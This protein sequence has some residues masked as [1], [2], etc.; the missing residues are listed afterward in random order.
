MLLDLTSADGTVRH[1][2]FASGSA[3]NNSSEA[4]ERLMNKEEIV[5][6]TPPRYQLGRPL[7]APQRRARGRAPGPRTGQKP[8]RN[9]Y[10]RELS[11]DNARPVSR[12]ERRRSVSSD[13][14][15]SSVAANNK[16]RSPSRSDSDASSRSVSRNGK[17]P[18]TDHKL[19]NTD[20]QKIQTWLKQKN[21]LLR[22]KKAEERKVERS[23]KKIEEKEKAEK[24]S[25]K[26]ES[27]LKVKEW[28]VKKKS[29]SRLLNKRQQKSK[30]PEIKC[31]NAVVIG[32]TIDLKTG[33][34]VSEEVTENAPEGETGE[35]NASGDSGVEDRGVS[36]STGADDSHP[37]E[38]TCGFVQAAKLKQPQINR[39]YRRPRSASA[40]I[41]QPDYTL[42]RKHPQSRRAVQQPGF[43]M[44]GRN[45]G[46]SP[47]KP[48]KG[49]SQ[50]KSR[51]SY[52][53]WLDQKRIQDQKTK[54]EEEQTQALAQSD[55]EVNEVISEVARK[56]I[57]RIK[58][59]GRR[60]DTGLKKV[61]DEANNYPR[62]YDKENEVVNTYRLKSANP[63]EG[64][65]RK[66]KRRA[67][68]ANEAGMER[69]G[70]PRRR[71][72]SPKPRVVTPAS[73]KVM[74][75][76][77]SWDEFSDYVWDKVNEDE[78]GDMV[79]SVTRP[80]PMGCDKTEDDKE[81]QHSRQN[82]VTDNS[83]PRETVQ[84]PTSA[85]DET[86][87]DL[88]EVSKC[89]NKDIAPHNEVER[90]TENVPEEK[91]KEN[92]LKVTFDTEVSYAEP[93][94]LEDSIESPR[95][96][97]TNEE[98]KD[99]AMGI[100]VLNLKTKE[101]Q[102]HSM[103][104]DLSDLSDESVEEDLGTSDSEEEALTY[105]IQQVEKEV[106][107]PE[108]IT[109]SEEVPTEVGVSEAAPSENNQAITS[110][111]DVCDIGPTSETGSDSNKAESTL[112]GVGGENSKIAETLPV[113]ADTGTTSPNEDS[114]DAG[115]A[116]AQTANAD[117]A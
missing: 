80:E 4:D 85:Q 5:T 46:P 71:A 101:K 48:T 76:R 9:T 79:D 37:S 33:D 93:A 8:R 74:Y 90:P 63:M 30:A 49:D 29:E 31:A 32:K 12:R 89:R 100:E 115:Q 81:V 82:E 7:S 28:M 64:E 109:I 40:R 25:K 52:D 19:K 94:V 61:D 43:V 103:G 24:E 35:Q 42:R 107:V 114:P 78:D 50:E 84:V 26:T 77:Q 15:S 34:D 67:K 117:V 111:E 3:S 14:R 13:S 39:L 56:R 75:Q 27:E 105:Q 110:F 62:S 59:G 2:T 10:G 83:P 58:S 92:K 99:P 17:E 96:S 65:K 18:V 36:C 11:A 57:E 91:V 102:I 98:T 70:S 41:N 44:K 108:T 51:M 88:F 20:N 45:M 97:E 21:R 55:P 87:E 47:P 22:K 66:K 53:Q 104:I 6:D 95:E 68:S 69:D 54:R 23:K 106:S 72:S 113:S 60:I 16:R 116:V 112:D 73:K 86:K 38:C 1:V